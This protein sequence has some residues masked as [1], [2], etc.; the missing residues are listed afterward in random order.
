MVVLA[1]RGRRPCRP[2]RAAAPRVGA[3]RCASSAA[4]ACVAAARRRG[5]RAASR[6][7]SDDVGRLVVVAASLP[8]VLPSVA[9]AC[10]DVEDVVDH[11][12][13]E[14]DARRRSRPARCHSR[15][16]GVGRRRRPSATL[17]LQQRAGLE[18]VHVA[19]LRARRAAGRRWPGRSPGRRPCRAAG[20]ARQ[21]AAQ[22]AP[23]A[24]AATPSSSGVSSS[25]ASACRRRRPAAPGPRRTHVHRRLAAAQDVVVHARHVVVHQRI[26]VDQFDRAGRAQRR[27][28]GRRATA[29]PAASTSS[30]RTRLPPSSTRVA[31]RVAEAGRRV[32]AGPSAS[33]AASTASSSASATQ[34]G[35]TSV[36]ASCRRPRLQLRRPRAP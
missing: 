24:P 34:V 4:C 20:G 6:P 13:G 33:S 29:S 32:G 16:R 9:E 31:H 15:A 27:V 7:S 5:A 14:A 26:G 12:E 23:A 28:G 36:A 11:L 18:A 8:A 21:Q 1:C 35:R 2:A 22:R 30:G 25:K 10:G 3:G 17:A 19:Q